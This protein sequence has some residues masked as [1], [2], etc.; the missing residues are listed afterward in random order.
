MIDVDILIPWFS[1]TALLLATGNAIWAIMTRGTRATAEKVNE[2]EG[3]M[4]DHDR[5][6]QSVESD[7]KHLPTKDEFNKMQVSLTE[8]R[9]ELRTV[10]TELA[11]VDR[12]VRR[13]DE[14]LRAKE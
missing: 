2:H 1:L 10:S 14:Y 8:V 13:I 7:I 11:G 4:I 6:I 3:K 12:T 5:R 9:G